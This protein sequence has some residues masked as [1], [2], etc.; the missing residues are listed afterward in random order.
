MK[1]KLVEITVDELKKRLS[2]KDK[3][4]VLID[5]RGNGVNTIQG[6]DLEI[7]LQ[8]LSTIENI[9]LDKSQEVILYC[10][11]GNS[12]KL[13]IHML[14]KMGYSNVKDLKGGFEEWK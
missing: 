10:N 3:E 11:T 9:L 7:A 13:G 12:S 1:N 6:T 14:E 4:F 2:D 8:D 5:I